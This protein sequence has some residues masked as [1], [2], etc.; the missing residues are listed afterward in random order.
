MLNQ[1]GIQSMKRLALIAIGVALSAC[2]STTSPPAATVTVTAPV[3]Q[4]SVPSS[5]SQPSSYAAPTP[6]GPKSVIGTDGTYLVGTDIQPGMYRTPGGSACYWARLRSLDTS[7]IIDN[8][9][10]TGPQVIEILPTDRAFKTSNCQTWTLESSPTAAIPPASASTPPA[11]PPNPTEAS[12]EGITCPYR[13]A[14]TLRT[15]QSAVVICD[16]GAGSYT[17]KGLRL[18]DGARI[19]VQGAVPTANGFTVTNNGT[20]YDVSRGGLVIYTEGDVYTES[21]IA[22]GP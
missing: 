2:G 13:A 11:L 22:S 10:S 1:P 3:S 15:A 6:T 12:Y 19:D 9:N 14:L 7:D 16:K 5:A 8:N 20:R 18:K 17:Y 4:P 21:A